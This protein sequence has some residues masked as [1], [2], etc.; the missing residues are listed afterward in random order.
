M[1]IF[2]NYWSVVHEGLKVTNNDLVT[3]RILVEIMSGFI[4]FCWYNFINSIKLVI[5]PDLD[6]D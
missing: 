3:G 4:L 2:D 1:G 5:I 6:N